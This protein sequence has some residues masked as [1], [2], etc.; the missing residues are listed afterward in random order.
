MGS[1]LAS[2][3]KLNEQHEVQFI[4]TPS[5]SILF[6][7]LVYFQIMFTSHARWKLYGHTENNQT[8]SS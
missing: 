8:N 3:S 4:I 7:S 5:I 2:E 1:A 6:F